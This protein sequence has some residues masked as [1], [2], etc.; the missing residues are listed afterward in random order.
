MTRLYAP[1]KPSTTETFI[2]LLAALTTSLAGWVLIH[3]ANL[4]VTTGQ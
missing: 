3:L 1:W 4:Y 2:P